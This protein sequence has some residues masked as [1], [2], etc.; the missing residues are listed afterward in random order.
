MLVERL[1]LSSAANAEASASASSS[2]DSKA[3]PLKQSTLSFK[4]KT[5]PAKDAAT[6]D[7]APAPKKMKAAQ[8]KAVAKVPVDMRWVSFA[9]LEQLGLTTGVRKVLDLAIV[10]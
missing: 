8:G 3:Q 5:T 2:A 7:S 4:R 9:E 1:V 10:S 6:Q